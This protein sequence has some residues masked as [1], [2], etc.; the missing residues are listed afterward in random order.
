MDISTGV[1]W[2]DIQHRTF[3]GVIVSLDWTGGN[4]LLASI[5]Y[6][7]NDWRW[8]TIAVT[9]PLVLAVITWWYTTQFTLML[10]V[11]LGLMSSM[12]ELVQW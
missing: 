7:A 9:S 10:C 4:M 11:I 2:F 3:A 12:L 6:F 5:A 1:E 8:L